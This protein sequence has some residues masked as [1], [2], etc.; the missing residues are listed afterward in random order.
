MA[1]LAQ[2][3]QAAGPWFP[4]HKSARLYRLP[5]TDGHS[6]TFPS[7]CF[8]MTC[9]KI[10]THCLTKNKR[11]TYIVLFFF[12]QNCL[13]VGFCIRL[14]GQLFGNNCNF[15]THYCWV[16][17]IVTIVASFKTTIFDMAEFESSSKTN[18]LNLTSYIEK[19]QSIFTI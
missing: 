11:I 4:Q 3:R 2:G 9:L 17:Q 7:S 5:T 8:H 19:L 6:P 13:Y 10:I 1:N 18:K 16:S 12:L 15:L 14:N